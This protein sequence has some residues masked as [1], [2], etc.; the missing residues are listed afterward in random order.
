MTE[1]QEAKALGQL[2]LQLNGVMM[3]KS[4]IRL[5]REKGAI[6]SVCHSPDYNRLPPDPDTI[7]GGKPEFRCNQCGML[8][9]YGR[10]GGVFAELENR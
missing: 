8:W 5:R 7:G 10:D 9:S 1:E 2:K 3:A 6:C 4:L